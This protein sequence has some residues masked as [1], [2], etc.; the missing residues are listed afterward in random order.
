MLL[1]SE[2]AQLMLNFSQ[3]VVGLIDFAALFV[4][5]V[6]LRVELV[7]VSLKFKVSALQR[8]H[9]TV[10]VIPDVLRLGLK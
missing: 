10:R 7:L 8:S 4:Q 6:V 3:L 5:Q 2:G 1:S 9:T